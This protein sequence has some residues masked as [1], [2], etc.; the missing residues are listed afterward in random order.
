[1]PD[2]AEEKQICPVYN[3]EKKGIDFYQWIN[4]QWVF[5]GSTVA[6]A[7]INPEE[8]ETIEWI[9]DHM[10]QLKDLVDFNYLVNV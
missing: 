6:D 10:D 1:M 3:D 4:G 9:N 7:E 8:K 5:R 2:T